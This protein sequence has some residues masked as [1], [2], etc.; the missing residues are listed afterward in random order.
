MA[1]SLEAFIGKFDSET[2]H[3][4]I[5]LHGTCWD[6]DNVVHTCRNCV[7]EFGSTIRK[8]H[9]RICGGI[10]CDTCAP[11]GEAA[12]TVEPDGAART[13]DSGWYPGKYLGR[14]N[15]HSPTS[16]GAAITTASEGNRAC[17]GCRLG[18]T[19][20]ERLRALLKDLHM[21]QERPTGLMERSP[22]PT[23]ALVRGSLYGEG[24]KTM[25][26]TDGSPAHSEG[27]FELFNKSDFVCCLRVIP[28]GSETYRE[29]CRPSYT[30][31]LPGECFFAEF[32][33][34]AL[35]VV[36]LFGN[37]NRPDART[38][39]VRSARE[40]SASAISPSCLIDNFPNLAI[41]RIDC[42][43][44]NAIL[45]YQGQGV[46]EIRKGTTAKLDRGTTGLLKSVFTSHEKLHDTALDMSTNAENVIT[47]FTTSSPL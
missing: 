3:D 4:L 46:V 10:Y 41:Y 27:Y 6:D 12:V 1:S 37:P 29:A 19:P 26:R 2:K 33:S 23:I 39:V 11:I 22:A 43:H 9:C 18:E 14:K 35:E 30:V 7:V 32:N 42:A 16:S 45:K 20:N 44:K 34:D 21:N 13:V 5:E 15:P 24:T 36:V 38:P 17:L 40:R 47:M 31:I 28:A 8:H 25:Q